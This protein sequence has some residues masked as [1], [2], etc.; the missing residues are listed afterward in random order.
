MVSTGSSC[1]LLFAFSYTLSCGSV[2]NSNYK[3]ISFSCLYRL[4]PET[5]GMAFSLYTRAMSHSASS[6]RGDL[7]TQQALA[8]LYRLK[9]QLFMHIKTKHVWGKTLHT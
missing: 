7:V 2:H 1:C 5:S 3:L 4:L 9:C 6:Q 8:A